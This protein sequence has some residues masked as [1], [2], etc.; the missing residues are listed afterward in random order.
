[1]ELAPAYRAAILRWAEPRAAPSPLKSRNSRR[2]CW[3]HWHHIPHR[4]LPKVHHWQALD[5]E[6]N[7]RARDV[8]HF[9]TSTGHIGRSDAQ[10]SECEPPA[11][12]AEN[13]PLSRRTL[14]LTFPGGFAPHP[15]AQF[16]ARPDR[17]VE[18]CQK[19]LVRLGI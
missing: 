18:H 19:P 11:V 6:A 15:G 7:R 1:M 8:C 9:G 12:I 14:T 4:S 2:P 17:I 16:L 3:A 13:R 5:P 10:G